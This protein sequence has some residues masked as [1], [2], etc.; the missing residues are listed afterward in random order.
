MGIKESII[1]LRNNFIC[2]Y[3]VYP[4]TLIVGYNE[5]MKI[6][7]LENY[8]LYTT[9]EFKTFMGMDVIRSTQDSFL[10]VALTE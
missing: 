6:K 4:D 1:T 8:Y 3:D 2:K 10:K 7:T 5:L 9:I